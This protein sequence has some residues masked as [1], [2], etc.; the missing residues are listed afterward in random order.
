[1]DTNN[2]KM[3][4]QAGPNTGTNFAVSLERNGFKHVPGDGEY[5]QAAAE[6]TTKYQYAGDLP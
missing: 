5:L 2:G 6:G 4:H 1:M 3:C